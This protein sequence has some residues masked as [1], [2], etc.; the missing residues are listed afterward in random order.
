[1]NNNNNNNNNNLVEHDRPAK[2]ATSVKDLRKLFEN[3]QQATTVTNNNKTVMKIT[4]RAS[5]L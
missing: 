4:E 2:L 5:E 3:N 1:M